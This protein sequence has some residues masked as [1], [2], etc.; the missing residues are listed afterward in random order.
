M[1]WSRRERAVL[2]AVFVRFVVAD[3]K[4]VQVKLRP[5]YS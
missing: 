5:P 4:I 1:A 3:K 2:D